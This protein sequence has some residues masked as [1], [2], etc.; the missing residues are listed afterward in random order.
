MKLKDLGSLIKQTLTEYSE[1]RVGRLAAAL[2]YYTIFSIAPLLVIVIALVGFFL[3]GGQQE[4]QEQIINQ[5]G[6]LLGSEVARDVIETMVTGTQNQGANILATVI[7]VVSLLLG[8]SGVFVQLQE[9]MNT[10]W[11]V[12][13]E[14]GGWKNM[15]MKRFLSFTMVLGIGFLLLVSLVIS[16]AISAVG[17]YAASLIPGSAAVWQWANSLISFV[18]ITFLFAVIYK[19]L[20]DVKVS[21][22]DVW[23]GAAITA[24]L[25]TVGK[26]AIGIYLGSRGLS[27]AYGAAGALLIVL[28]WVYYSSQI[29][30]IGAEFSQVYASRFGSGAVPEAG[31]VRLSDASS[32]LEGLDAGDTG[33]QRAG[34]TG[35]PGREDRPPSQLPPLQPERRPDVLQPAGPS[36]LAI[37]AVLATLVGFVSGWVIRR[38]R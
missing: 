14:G 30:F 13:Q 35:I 11:D 32:Y 6:V 18:V 21:W 9:A 10:I 12:R 17:N 28:L 23:L 7:G 31:A 20:P 15:L 25:F 36:L 33:A 8:A 4:A 27:D 2:S 38:V 26:W 19:V 29:L 22:R 24:L 5:V 34:Q 16:A 37:S 3:Q 1:D